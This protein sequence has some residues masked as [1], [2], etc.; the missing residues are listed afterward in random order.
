MTPRIVYILPSFQ[1]FAYSRS[2]LI[3][4]HRYSPFVSAVVVDDS[5]PDWSSNYGWWQGTGG[6]CQAYRFQ[7]QGGLTRSWNAG[8][9]IARRLTPDYIVCGNNDVLFSPN[10]WQPMCLMLEAGYALA[11]PVSNAPGVT[12]PNG[13]QHVRTYLPDYQLTD[14]PTYIAIAA[15]RLRRQWSGW[16]IPS[17]VNGFFM[18]AKHKTWQDHGYSPELPFPPVIHELPTG[19]LNQTP[20][21]TGQEDWLQHELHKKGLGTCIVPSS[22]IF[23][24]RSVARGPQ[25]ARGD[26]LR[27][28]QSG[29]A[30]R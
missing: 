16:A 19:K 22:F 23:H 28:T 27:M 2:C 17:P 12:A 29:R 24:Y 26:S 9:E 20:T 18:M 7:S 21:M 15:N 6:P 30:L 8:I 10:W 13:L 25:Y 1:N 4:L 3:S 11:G 5:S 14:D